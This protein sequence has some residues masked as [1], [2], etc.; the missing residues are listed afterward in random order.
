MVEFKTFLFIEILKLYFDASL[1]MQ[2]ED[3]Q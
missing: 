3:Y 2:T 1:Q